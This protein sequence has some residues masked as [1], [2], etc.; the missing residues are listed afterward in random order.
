MARKKYIPYEPKYYIHYDKK[1]GSILS[2]SPEKL[3]TDKHSIEISF[4]EFKLFINGSRRP[5]DYAI[6]YDKK[7]AI[8]TQINDVLQGFTFRNKSF[9]WINNAPTK[10]TELTTT[11]NNQDGCWEFSLS[12]TAR[13]RTNTDVTTH[14]IFFV[15]LEDDF[16]FLIKTII[17]KIKDLVEKDTV[18]VPFESA[19]EHQIDK[20]SIS[21]KTYFRT[22][23]LKIHD[24]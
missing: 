1:T 17:I 22:Y 4:N 24:K 14:A 20:I 10:N 7:E 19:I 5:Q 11:W 9:E 6:V 13:N 23:G 2:I 3:P 15:T 8:I 16:D 18:V 21:A 12:D